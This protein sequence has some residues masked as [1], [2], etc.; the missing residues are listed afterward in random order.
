MKGRLEGRVAIVTASAGA[1]IGQA[2]VRRLAAEGAYVVVSDIHEGRTMKV[3]EDLRSKGYRAIGVPCDVSKKDQVERLVEITLREYGRIDILVNNA[4]VNR[5][6][7]VVEMK[8]ED[9]DYIVSV[10][11]KGV[12]LCCK[13][14]LPHMLKQRYGRIINISS[15]YAWMPTRHGDACYAATK[16]GILAF[17]RC[18][19]LE[20]A[21]T[22]ITV[23]AV[24]PGLVPHPYM[25][26]VY[27]EEV[28]RQLE[29]QI[30]LGRGAKPEEIASVVAFL[31][32]DDASY[33]TGETI[34][35]S[36]GWYFK[37]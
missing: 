14:V 24:A 6:A 34:C 8:E 5:P 36:G 30:P 11:L 4:G 22:G 1:G 13:A 21:G 28:L 7:P 20:V 16:A 29:S 35:V 37:A 31:A 15:V 27:P 33:I 32:S 18:L 26:R 17:T 3:A 10:N 9:W 12:F 25:N 23:N 2:T 19:A